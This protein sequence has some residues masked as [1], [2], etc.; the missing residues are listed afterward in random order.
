MKHLH[1]PLSDDLYAALKAEAARLETPAT[2]L[3][4]EAIDH[5]L[6]QRRREA[7]TKA[8]AQYAASFGG[9]AA[10]LDTALERAGAA[11]LGN[12]DEDT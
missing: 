2:K 3:A 8:I 11:H 6:A 1:L 5:W 9:T 10:D 7:V 4:R 12:L